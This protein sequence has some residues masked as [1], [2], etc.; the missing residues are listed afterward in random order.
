MKSPIKAAALFD[1][2]ERVWQAARGERKSPRRKDIDAAKL[3]AVLPH[4]AILDVVREGEKLDFR[5]RLLGE[6]LTKF[7]GVNLTGALHTVVASDR[8]TA[9]PFYE[10]YVRC[11]TSHHAETLESEIRNR[12]DV[13]I[14]IACRLWP[15]SDDGVEV[16]GLLG[17]GLYTMPMDASR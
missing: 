11:V 6:H 3:G 7:Y 13:P 8:Q 10:A 1:R 5:Y 17:A 14:H 15:L 16:S 4:L 12:N 2:V 9:R